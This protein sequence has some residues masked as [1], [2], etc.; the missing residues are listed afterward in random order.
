MSTDKQE[1]EPG[2]QSHND[3]AITA[4]GTPESA[5]SEEVN[6]KYSKDETQGTTQKHFEQSTD[7]K[8]QQT[9]D[10]AVTAV[11]YLEEQLM[12]EREAREVM[13]Y[14]PE[15]CTYPKVLRQLVF[16][17]LTCLRQN[18]GADIG[19]C[20]LCLIQCHSTHE[21]VELFSRRAFGCDCGTS[22]MHHGSSCVLRAKLARDEAITA[23]TTSSISSISPRK[24]PRLRAGSISESLAFSTHDLPQADDIPC[25]DN[26]Y[27]HNFQGRFCSCGMV[28][29]PIQETRTMHQC[30]L[31]DVCG[32]DW[33][34]QDCILGYK[35]GLFHKSVEDSGENKLDNLPSPGLEASADPPLN[36]I[37]EEEEIPHFPD[38][39][40]F[41]E[42]ICWRCVDAH[43]EAF[44]ELK[45][46]SKVTAT[47]MPHLD[48]VTSADAW[49]HQYKKYVSGEPLAKKVKTENGHSQFSYSIFLTENFKEELKNLQLEANSPISKL[50]HR[51]DFL[52]HDDPVYEP[53]KEE[54]GSSGSSTGSL[55]EL[56]SNALL[57][58]PAPQ[59]IEGLHAYGVM[60]AKLRDFFKGFVDQNKVVTEEEVREFFG[61]MKRD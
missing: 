25:L 44:D 48:M 11:D 33:F 58:L 5:V 54:A 18:N 8:Y 7:V 22:R 57:S 39:N 10:K 9:E 46:I 1:N 13:P 34:H 61:N 55:F 28:Y 42:F 23:S 36:S 21:L 53:P 60:K 59:A 31:G 49:E 40:T 3:D 43:R 20:Y 37:P 30:Y 4:G 47:H 12:L 16:A 56:G 15:T 51:F 24:I 29:N 2:Q 50:L 14:D 45:E 32:E 41:G 19:V 17:C 35:P 26:T 27:N 52:G 38:M 6:V